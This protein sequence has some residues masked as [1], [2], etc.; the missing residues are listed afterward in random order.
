MRAR[1][2]VRG[3]AGTSFG[4]PPTALCGFSRHPSSLL[5]CSR[6]P[7]R[8]GTVRAA[9]GACSFASVVSQSFGSSVSLDAN[10]E[11]EHWEPEVRSWGEPSG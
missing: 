5:G 9:A 7:W 6:G 10:A 4:V 2:G 11:L 3:S 1:G 8:V